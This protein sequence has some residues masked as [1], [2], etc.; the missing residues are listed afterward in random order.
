MPVGKISTNVMM[1]NSGHKV[2]GLCINI[3]SLAQFFQAVYKPT[4]VSHKVFV[5]CTNLQTP[6]IKFLTYVRTT[7]AQLLFSSVFLYITKN[8]FF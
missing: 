5:S 3:Q 2:F 6:D 7:R 1:T 4:N 8:C